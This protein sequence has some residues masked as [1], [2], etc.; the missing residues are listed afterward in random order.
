MFKPE[1]IS[2]TIKSPK[3]LTFA[4]FAQ[5]NERKDIFVGP[6]IDALMGKRYDKGT[7]EVIREAFSQLTIHKWAFFPW[8]NH[9][10]AFFPLVKQK[11]GYLPIS[12]HCNLCQQLLCHLSA[13]LPTSFNFVLFAQNYLIQTFI[14][15]IKLEHYPSMRRQLLI[16]PGD[17]GKNSAV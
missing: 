13:N 1:Y 11:C 17:Q 3:Q 5:S 14:D 4:L 9:K 16:G 6:S 8:T 7:A 15:P 2:H 12:A 10:S